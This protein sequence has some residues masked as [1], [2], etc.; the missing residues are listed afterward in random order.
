MAQAMLCH[1]SFAEVQAIP[2]QHWQR[3]F[4]L[5]EECL[6][7]QSRCVQSH[8]VCAILVLHRLEVALPQAVSSSLSA[9]LFVSE[10]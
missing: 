5:L 9:V 8:C 4:S 6:K 7:L 3:C 2:P 10:N 1:V